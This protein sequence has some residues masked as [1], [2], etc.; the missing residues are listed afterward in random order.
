MNHVSNLATQRNFRP[1]YFPASNFCAIFE[2]DMHRLYSLALLLTGEHATAEQCFQLALR[3][4]IEGSD[5][6]CGWERSWSRR[7]I[8]KQAI[9]LVRPKPN[10]LAPSEV[11]RAKWE[12]TPSR[13]LALEPFERFVF[14]MTVLEKYSVRET[15]ALLN[16][17]PS[18]VAKARI[19]VLETLGENPVAPMDRQPWTDCNSSG[20]S[21]T[22]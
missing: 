9:Q 13:L 7:A 15:A 6:F 18:E 20:L 12:D 22:A 11:R 16:S 5:V 8:V 1:S 2:S 14:A 3:Q 4:C 19:R 17:V 21:A 10:D